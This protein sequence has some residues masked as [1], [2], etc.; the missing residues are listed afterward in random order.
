MN[1]QKERI[2]S[3][4]SVGGS[5]CVEHRKQKIDNQYHSLFCDHQ[6][7]KKLNI[8]GAHHDS[9]RSDV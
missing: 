8:S 6:Q 5:D 3:A 7:K 2:T 4:Q 9:T 1:N